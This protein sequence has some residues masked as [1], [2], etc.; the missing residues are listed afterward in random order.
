MLTPMVFAVAVLIAPAAAAPLQVEVSSDDAGERLLVDGRA[1]F[2]RGVNW[3]YIP[4]GENYAYNLWEQPDAFIEDV[5][6]QEMGLLAAAGINSIRLYP[7]IPPRWVEHIYDTYGITTM[8]NPLVGRYGL[9]IDGRWV[10]VVDY[11]D[12][13]TRQLLKEQTLAEVA[14]Y[15]D[16][17][18]VLLY[19]LGNESNYGLVWD[20]F[21]IAD[22]PPEEQNSAR[23]RYLYSLFGEI[24][25][26]IQ[27]QNPHQPVAL[28]NGDLQY[29]DLIKQEMPTLQIFGTNVYRGRSARDLY[30]RVR[31]ELGLPVLYT[32]F[33]ADAFN[34]R[35][36]REDHL[37]QAS[38]LKDQWQ[39]VYEQ[40]WGK[41]LAGNVIGGYTF[42][43]SDGWWK[44]GQDKNL[45]VQ[46]TTASWANGGYPEDLVPGGNNMNEEWFGIAAKGPTQPD[47][48]YRSYPRAA[49]YVLQA[50]YRLDPY[51]PG[52]DLDAVRAHF[53]SIQ[54]ADYDQ[55]Y[56]A[57]LA[58]RDTE[59]LK[60]ARV[61]DL[62]ME[63][64]TTAS[65]GRR[66]LDHPDELSFDH[67]ESFYLDLGVYPTEAISGDLVLNVVGNA[68]QNRLDEI[69]YENRGR[70]LSVVGADGETV[71][72]SALERLKIHRAAMSWEHPVFRLDAYYRAG[73]YH[74]GYEGDFFGLYP[75]AN[76][77]ENLDIYNADAP[78]G[79]EIG[80]KQ[81]LDGLKVA[82]GPQIT[83]G[84]NPTVIAK[85]RRAAGN[86]SAT[87]MHQEDIAEQFSVTTSNVIPERMTRKSTVHL[88]WTRGPLS[89]DLGGIM[90]GTDRLGETFTYVQEA[91]GAESYLESGYDV[92]QDEVELA[93]TLGAKVRL[94]AQAGPVQ[95]YGQGVYK[96][97]VAD[98]GSDPTVTFTGWS[99]K[100]AGRGN[101]YGATTGLAL[102]LGSVQVA[103][104]FLYQKPLIGPN[105]GL[106][107]DYD[108]D[109]GWYRPGVG[110]RNIRDDAFAV[111]ENR[112][113]T[114]FELLLVY[115][116]T[117]G[118]W[119]WYWDNDV[120][121][122]APFAASLDAVYRIQPTSR[123]ASLAF[124]E[125]GWLFAFPGAPPAQDVWE[126]RSRVIVNPRG[127]LRIVSQLYGGQAQGNGD[128][129]R[130]VTRGGGS[131]RL[132][133]QRLAVEGALKLWDWGPYDYH[134]DFNLTYPVQVEGDISLGMM[135]PRLYLPYGRLGLAM[136]WRALDER[137]EGY[138]MDPLDPSAWGSELELG[139]YL[140]VSL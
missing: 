24:T 132:W 63:L 129:P 6:R 30:Q 4:V 77:G 97:L 56:V 110:L 91:A 21:E 92:L 95:W 13:R 127:D 107:G 53:A 37:L 19:L 49:Y 60:R 131:A 9:S 108:P 100:E 16:T 31:D 58:S 1:T 87:V 69:Y 68:A 80:F 111:L 120:R 123:D 119:M 26:E 12:E 45:S 109:T 98:A 115:D 137:S 29:L 89:L 112:E 130:L 46:D 17:R 67:T 64:S 74:W 113:A 118:T 124:S 43:W 47:G 10:P 93:D 27:G 52:V 18:G 22:L 140:H 125:E 48:S 2:V 136:K 66:S 62:R 133:Y 121:E 25:R 35:T 94:T 33:G 85:Y 34:A 78:L 70:E 28:C 99:L 72:L 122:D 71:D 116:P 36:G 102:N 126:I 134:R 57:H 5:L 59:I 75:E 106:E 15:H 82:F 40:S 61:D 81:A 128:D 23:A 117:P 41:G 8:L 79:M 83:W 103:P 105:P 90:A 88:G 55:R 44:Y 14:P 104:N 50:A 54:V 11:S 139:T 39:E 38:Y 3:D 42:Q 114:A 76:Y 84:A 135:R 96:G 138:R 86:W 73:H 20:S 51:E 65:Q 7:G 101:H 32:E